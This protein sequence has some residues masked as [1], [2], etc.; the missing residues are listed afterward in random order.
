[1]K[2]KDKLVKDYQKV[3]EKLSQTL[4]IQASRLQESIIDYH[5]VSKLETIRDELAIIQNRTF[6]TNARLESLQNDIRSALTTLK[7]VNETFGI[8]KGKYY[9]VC[10]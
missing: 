8:V 10:P 7:L 5:F 6:Q 2:K 4:Y 1:M 9:N 3:A